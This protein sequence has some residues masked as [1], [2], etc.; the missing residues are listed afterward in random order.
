MEFQ[1]RLW[2]HL[3]P[4]GRGLALARERRLRGFAACAEWRH[5]ECPARAEFLR[6]HPVL[7]ERARRLCLY[8][9]LRHRSFHRRAGWPGTVGAGRFLHD[10]GRG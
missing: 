10:A 5:P 9:Y 2:R 3:C 4:Q 8:R 7:P 6:R 1:L